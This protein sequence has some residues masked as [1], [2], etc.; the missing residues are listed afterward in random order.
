M[1]P[2]IMVHGSQDKVQAPFGSSGNFI[3]GKRCQVVVVKVG[4]DESTPLIVRKE[5]VGLEIDT[6]FTKKDIGSNF[7]QVPD[8]SRLAYA[9]EVIEILLKNGKKEAAATLKTIAPLRF[10][11]YV[12][13]PGTFELIDDNE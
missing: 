6:I 1:I 11:M 10:D 8:G 5:L 7:S 4:P 12:L 3:L 9:E 2:T 13:E